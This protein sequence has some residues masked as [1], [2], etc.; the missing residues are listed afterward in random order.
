MLKVLLP[1]LIVLFT[2]FVKVSWQRLL[3][4]AS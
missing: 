2:S 3:L 1:L 4:V